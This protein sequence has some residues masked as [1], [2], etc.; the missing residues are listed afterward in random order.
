MI[1][2][3]EGSTFASKRTTHPHVGEHCC[4][5]DLKCG[6]ESLVDTLFDTL[7]DTLLD[8]AN[9]V[10]SYRFLSSPF[11]L[12][13]P[14]TERGRFGLSKNLIIFNLL[15]WMMLVQKTGNVLW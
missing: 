12:T 2:C 15:T 9:A 11:F 10:C 13:M 14:L 6:A 1:I 3:V 5:Q 8:T 7:F 4:P